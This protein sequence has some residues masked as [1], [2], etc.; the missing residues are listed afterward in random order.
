MAEKVKSAFEQTITDGVLELVKD[1]PDIEK[2]LLAKLKKVGITPQAVT[3]KVKVGAKKTKDTGKQHMRFPLVLKAISAKTNIALVGAAGSGKTTT[4]KKVSEALSLPFYSKSVSVQTGI[5]EFFGYQDANGKY[6]ETLF[7]TAYEKGGIF[8]VDEFDAGNPNVL[9]SLNQ[10]TA[11]GECAFPDGMV[12]KH[13]DFIVVMAGNTYGHGATT[14]Y[15]GRNKIDAAT[16]DRFVFIDFPYDEKLEMELATNKE[17]CERVQAM[18]AKAIDKRVKTII[19][20]RATFYGQDLLEA[21]VSETDVL[22][23]V[24]YKN[25]SADEIKLINVP[26]AKKD[27]GIPVPKE[28]DIEAN[29]NVTT[30]M[31]ISQF[32]ILEKK[33]TISEI[34]EFADELYRQGRHV[35]SSDSNYG[36]IINTI[37]WGSAEKDSSYWSDMYE[38]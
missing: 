13:E 5:H 12:K 2:A 31:K 34:N 11:N 10:A 3:V 22:R 21:G 1:N 36:D 18:R 19:S 17:W 37:S 35:D 15:V 20:P 7:R 23:I 24:V 6:V 27:S 16:L 8:L 30:R 9:A 25:L 14:E 26:K 28:D 29:K 38:R 33:M 4:V 32:R